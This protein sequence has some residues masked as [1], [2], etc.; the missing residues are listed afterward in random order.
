MP[1]ATARLWQRPSALI[2]VMLLLAGPLAALVTAAPASA[3]LGGRTD[4][5]IDGNTEGPNDWDDPPASMLEL[6]NIGDPCGN[7]VLDPTTLSGKLDDL[8]LENPD[9]QPGNVSASADLCEG[10]YGLDVAVGAE[11]DYELILYGA[12]RRDDSK[13]ATSGESTVFFPLIGPQPG[14]ADDILVTF[15]YDD[16]AAGSEAV[17]IQTWN[18]STW[19]ATEAPAGSFEA[20]VDDPSGPTF[21]EFA[22]DL[23]GTGIATADN[24]DGL[25]LLYIFSRTGQLNSNA[26]LDDFVGPVSMQVN[27]CADLRITKETTPSRPIP[28]AD[29]DVTVSRDGGGAVVAPDTGSVDATL[30]VPGNETV[31]IEDIVP[32]GDYTVE[33][34]A[35]PD[36]WTLD[37]IT[38][39]AIDPATG[40]EQRFDISPGGEQFPVLPG[41]QPDCLVSNVGPGSVT[42][43]KVGVGDPASFEFAAPGLDP[44]SFTLDNAGFEVITPLSPGE[45]TITEAPQDGW[46]LV[47]IACFGG[48]TQTDVAAGSVTVRPGQSDRIVCTFVNVQDQPEA[49]LT[50]IKQV[51][52]PDGTTFPFTIDGPGAPGTVDLTPPSNGS[53]TIDGLAPDEAGSQYTITE[54]VPA[55][56]SAAATECTVDGVPTQPAPAPGGPAT[57]TLLPGQ[58][59]VCSFANE[60]LPPPP[61]SLTVAK[62]TEP[63]G[64]LPDGA[65][66]FDFRVRGGSSVDRFGLVHGESVTLDPLRPGTYQIDEQV[67]AGWAVDIDCSDPDAVLGGA[68]QVEVSLEPGDA[69]TC[70]YTNVLLGALTIVKE[71]DPMGDQVF[72]FS[73]FRGRTFYALFDLDDD[74]DPTSDPA[75]GQYSNATI[76]AALPPGS[77]AVEERVPDGWTLESIEC[78]GVAYTVDLDAGRVVADV[79]PG[80]NGTCTYRNAAVTDPGG[81]GGGSGGSGGLPEAG[82]ELAL[83]VLG[84]LAIA[85][86]TWLMRL[87][88]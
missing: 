6:V 81:G 70:T 64:T 3:A 18:G 10:W 75:N 69:V 23:S 17:F 26:D 47:S 51:T 30:T 41:S 72:P 83:G 25:T 20:A 8:D 57:V 59:A 50:V 65:A 48:D 12:W 5:Q 61:A 33:E 53:V 86:G 39:R 15:E 19:V 79:M 55:G 2:L 14:K 77:Y 16:S 45:Y 80:T 60:P 62:L 78:T 22:L 68:G 52:D 29:F 42:I 37:S 88:R 76:K 13:S 11:G 46:D 43:I 54:Q 40:E 58:N 44:S 67:P 35:L 73:S 66:G 56:W 38:C 85:L 63:A 34:V 82:A 32:G 27:P 9:P 24:C 7:G 74:G 87:S 49:T 31:V 21:G 4:F 36:G 28:P 84:I 71:A 1:R